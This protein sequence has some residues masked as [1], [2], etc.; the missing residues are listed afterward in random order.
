MSVEQPR[1]EPPC[2]A[3]V[4]T[5]MANE[6]KS[7]ANFMRKERTAAGSA[8][9]AGDGR[10]VTRISTK[11]DPA[12]FLGPGGGIVSGAKRV[13]ANNEKGAKGFGPGGRNEFKVVQSAAADR[14]AFWTGFQVAKVRLPGKP[15]LVSMKL[16]VTE[17]FRREKS[18]WRLVHRHG[19][20]LAKPAGKK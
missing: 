4:E 11:R 16:R 7:F 18:S 8:Y 1:P 15:G 6:Q 19:D 17:I 13:I 5:S 2:P 12:T 10:L 14:L 9:A 20:M 3:W